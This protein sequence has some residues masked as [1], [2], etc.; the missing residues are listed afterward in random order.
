MCGETVTKGE[1]AVEYAWLQGHTDT[2]MEM[3]PYISQKTLAE[4]FC[5][6][7]RYGK[8]E[9]VRAIIRATDISPNTE[10]KGTNALYLACRAKNVAIVEMLI[11]KGADV[12]RMSKWLVPN[13]NA[14]GHRETEEP[15][16][17][18]IHAVIMDW[19]ASNNVACQQLLR[20]LL[21]G[22][23]DLEVK[24]D[25]GD[26]PL[27]SLFS[28]LDNADDVV[29]KGLLQ[30][31]AD[32]RAV[33][34]NGN[35]IVQRYLACDSRNIQTLKMLFEYGA[36]P[37]T[38]GEH[39]DTIIHSV[40]RTIQRDKSHDFTLASIK[41][42]IE[43]GT[44]CDVRNKRELTAVEYAANNSMC[45]LDTFI[46]LLRACSDEDARKRCTWKLSGRDTKEE[47]VKYIHE[48]QKLGVSLEERDDKGRTVLLTSVGSTDLFDAFIECGADVNAVDL[49]SQG[50]LHHYITYVTRSRGRLDD[51][52]REH[53]L[54]QLVNMG[55]DPL[56]VCT[57][58][59][60][61]TG[62]ILT[63]DSG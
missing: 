24:D 44:P 12:H 57:H 32:A 18:P 23:A 58:G 48:L 4:L 6:C 36:S 53:R 40:L 38:I 8:L 30:A 33:D 59:P 25:D 10:W 60:T 5:Q 52:T 43:K 3:L 9:A 56:K 11:A 46:V 50:V 42:L 39:G 62:S 49:E 7:C 14:C 54:V 41:F 16:R 45:Q 31:G 15:L 63:A 51:H 21:N 13:R 17:A 2:I 35:S 1:T 20:L 61:N 22:G 37:K 29:V 34:K 47:T 27:L 19:K 28:R 55:L 26:T